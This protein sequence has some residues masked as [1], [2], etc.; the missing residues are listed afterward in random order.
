MAKL[1][2][3]RPLRSL[4]RTR[5][6]LKLADVSAFSSAEVG[7][8]R[9]RLELKQRISAAFYQ[10][11]ECLNRTRLELKQ[12]CAYCLASCTC[13]LIVPDWN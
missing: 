10:R 3:I 12:P 1:F 8:N 7:L 5:L 6:E 9:T 2:H 11:S 13:A 4:N